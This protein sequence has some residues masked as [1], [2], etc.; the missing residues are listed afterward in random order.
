MSASIYSDKNNV[1]DQIML[2]HD[3]RDSR[4]HFDEIKNFII[5]QYGEISPEWK[6]YGKNSGWLLKMIN[7]KRNVMFVVPCH[8]YFK[9]AFTFGDKASQAIFNSS[10]PNR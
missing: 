3:L 7:H 1:P 5:N 4:N 8:G 9:V 10:V 2:Y 6:H